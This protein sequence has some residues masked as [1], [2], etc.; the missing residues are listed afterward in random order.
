MP[1]LKSFKELC[2]MTK[3]PETNM[4][5][6]VEHAVKTGAMKEVL[7]DVFEMT[8]AGKF[9]VDNIMTKGM[10]RD[11]GSWKCTK[12]GVINNILNGSQCLKC[13]YSFKDNLASEELQKK[14]RKLQY[15]EVT[16]RETLIFLLGQSTGLAMNST[17]LSKNSRGGEMSF[18]K[19]ITEVFLPLTVELAHQFPTVSQDEISEIML[20]L[21]AAKTQPIIDKAI[22]K[23]RE[24]IER[25]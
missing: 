24:I 10:S 7:P 8:E 17:Y 9:V 20:Q 3:I 13:N 16:D 5:R 25:Y 15:P 2:A 1:T 11:A 14:N 22:K 23:L 12:C 21:D 4:R 6:I 18:D 19:I